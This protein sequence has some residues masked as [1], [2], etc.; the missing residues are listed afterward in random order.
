MDLFVNKLYSQLFWE[1]GTKDWELFRSKPDE[2]VCAKRIDFAAREPQ[3]STARKVALLALKIIL[4]PWG[5]YC[6]TRWL[7]QRLIMTKV[8][9]IQ[10]T[11]LKFFIPELTTKA[12]DA[13]RLKMAEELSKKGFVVRHVCFDH[14]GT[15]LS[16]MAVIHPDHALN[17]KWV[18]QACG[19]F[20]PIEHYTDVMVEHYH[21]QNFNV[22]FI[23]GPGAGR[24]EG[25]ATPETIGAAQ[26]LGISFLETAVKAKKIALAGY[27]LGGAAMGLAILKHK[28]K[29][30]SEVEYGAMRIMSF[31][32]VSTV[33][34]H[35]YREVINIESIKHLIKPLVEWAGCEMDSVEASKKLQKLNIPE[36]IIQ[37]TDD[38]SEFD[39]D[40]VIPKEATLGLC[41]HQEG[42]VDKTKT[43]IRL[44]GV[45]HLDVDPIA[46]AT[47]SALRDWDAPPP[48]PAP[49]PSPAPVPPPSL[50]NRVIRSLR[51]LFS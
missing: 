48:P 32:R 46:L 36:V 9:P 17:G 37:R 16:G 12:L 14:N 27:S 43:F 21:K 44:P 8:F 2:I 42:I 20:Q 13:Q 3:E 41:L 31:D 4:L 22:L 29:K 51:Y 40:G 19:N 49:E 11:I 35:R 33:C 39:S 25:M 47:L 38:A 18:L 34:R 23:N 5:L 30:P 15:K 26:E 1:P 45:G 24:S 50:R 10:S 6:G 28:F 7:L